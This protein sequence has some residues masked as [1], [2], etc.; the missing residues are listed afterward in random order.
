MSL[1]SKEVADLERYLDAT[2]GTLLYARKVLLVEG[3]AELFLI[4]KLVR[5]V[6][7]INLDEAGISVI[8]IFGT[9]FDA[10]MKLFGD[11]QMRK[12]CAVLTDGDAAE[13]PPEAADSH[14]A[15]DDADDDA[16]DIPPQRVCDRLR[17]HENDHVKVFA[18]DTTFERELTLPG[19]LRMFIAAAKELGAPKTAARLT[20][21][22]LALRKTPGEVAIINDAGKI[23]LKAATR[24][25]KARF[26]QVASKYMTNVTEM[27]PYITSAVDW[28]LEW[29]H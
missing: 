10:F 19:T 18:C 6:R 9:H 25:G 4:P 20:K 23:V 29:D 13:P 5:Q 16:D 21:A 14:G 27:P 11:E 22:H 17:E 3:P 24:F 7:G 28:L 2:R 26:A 8:P 15:D 12:P 1:S